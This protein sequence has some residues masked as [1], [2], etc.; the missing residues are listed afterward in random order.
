[1]GDGG[2]FMGRWVMGGG[3]GGLQ[4]GG[5]CMCDGGVMMGV[6]WWVMWFIDYGWVGG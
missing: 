5:L 2:W 1:M 6:Y 4:V 3:G